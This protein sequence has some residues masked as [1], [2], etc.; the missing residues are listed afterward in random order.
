MARHCIVQAVTALLVA[1]GRLHAT[2]LQLAIRTE[3]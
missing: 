3:A 1:D 2:E